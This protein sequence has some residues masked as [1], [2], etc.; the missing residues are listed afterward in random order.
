MFRNAFVF[1]APVL[2]SFTLFAVSPAIAQSTPSDADFDSI[3]AGPWFAPVL[4]GTPAT[5]DVLPVANVLT[6]YPNQVPVGASGNVLRVDNSTMSEDVVLRFNY[7]CGAGDET[8]DCRIS[9]GF[10]AWSMVEGQGIEVHVDDD[11]SYATPDYE[12]D[13]MI[14]GGDW[15]DSLIG[16]GYHDVTACGSAH[17]LDIV[18]EAGALVVLDGIVSECLTPVSSIPESVGMLKGRFE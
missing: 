6:L 16:S 8:T 10:A 12:W 4:S 14:P 9:Y 5:I 1:A 2:F 18:V 17:T 7:D 13:A 3:A 15:Q 11:G